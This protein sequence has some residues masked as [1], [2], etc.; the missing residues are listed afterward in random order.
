MLFDIVSE[1]IKTQF[2]DTSVIRAL[3][4][5]YLNNVLMLTVHTNNADDQLVGYCWHCR[6]LKTFEPVRPMPYA[7]E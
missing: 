7:N 2:P 5:T 1:F 4:F 3:R 6:D